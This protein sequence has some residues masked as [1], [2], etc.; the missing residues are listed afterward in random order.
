MQVACNDILQKNI[1]EEIKFREKELRETYN[2]LQKTALEN[3]FFQSVLDDYE[4]YYSYIIKEKEIEYSAFQAILD[5]LDKLSLQST[6]TTEQ[7]NQ[8]KNDQKEILTKLSFIK[9]ELREIMSQH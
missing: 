4:K 3:E 7:T 6:L 5:Y 8:L 2:D 9:R 1:E